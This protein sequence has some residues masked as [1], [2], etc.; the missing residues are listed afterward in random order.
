M[1]F[2]LSEV[3]F[4][5][6]AN[7]LDPV[8]PAL[9]DRMEVLEIPG[10]TEEEKLAIARDHLVQ[11]QVTNHG[12]TPEQLTIT[13]DALRAVIRG[14]TREAGVRNLER[15]IGALCRKAA[16]RR[17]E[18]DETPLDDHARRRRRDAG[19]ADR[20]STRRWRSAP[21][22]RAW[23]SAWRG[24]RPAATCC[25]SRRRGWRAPAR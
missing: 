4:I 24:R 23:R 25:S 16:R 2:D 6:T 10:Y 19:R 3:L 12:L 20:S 9:R 1:P 8:P 18:G 15:E 17:A 13:D 21:R 14:Y 7:V 22:S 5:T 11:K